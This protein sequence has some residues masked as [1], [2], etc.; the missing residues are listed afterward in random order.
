MLDVDAPPVL[1]ISPGAITVLGVGVGATTPVEWISPALTA[2]ESTHA[3]AIANAKRLILSVSPL[4]L[5]NASLL[6]RKQHSVNTYK[7]IDTA[8]CVVTN[9]W[10][11]EARFLTLT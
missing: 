1:G 4:R 8:S 5:G 3:R 7:T 9:I 2:P 10:R 6:A 11:W